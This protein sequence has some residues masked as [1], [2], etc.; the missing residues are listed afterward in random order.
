[1]TAAPAVPLNSTAA[2]VLA[3]GLETD[4]AYFEMGATIE[5]LPGATLAWMPGLTGSPAGAVIH[6]VD[7]KAVAA[8]WIALAER[9]LE[10]IGAS[11][12]R[13]YLDSHDAAADEQLRQAGYQ[14]RE[15]LVFIH[16]LP[17]PPAGLTLRPVTSDEDWERKLRFHEAADGSPD[18][19]HNR[20]ADWVALERSKCNH[21]MEAFLAEIDGET[22]G[23][24]GTV[25]GD[26]LL[27]MKNIVVH[28]AHRR[29][30]IGQSILCHAAATGR[31]Q[32]IFE[33]CIMAVR[34]EAGELFYRS[35]GMEVAG[36]QVEWSKQIKR[37]VV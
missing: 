25:W 14:V 36:I 35:Q 18:G 7:P 17:D 28:S 31:A 22:V 33:V 13:I 9:R 29:R 6:R 24:I 3:R 16:S 26:G 15:E 34:G 27:R 23:A 8:S 4:R 19:H 1:M 11:L 21:G 12:A 2:S 30:S 20:A 37:A 32:G 5:L 10:D